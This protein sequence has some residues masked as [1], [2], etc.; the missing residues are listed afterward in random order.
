MVKIAE[1]YPLVGGKA[2][3]VMESMQTGW[4]PRKVKI[5]DFEGVV[6]PAEVPVL[7]KPAQ[8]AYGKGQDQ[9]FE[10]GPWQA[11]VPSRGKQAPT[12]GELLKQG[13]AKRFS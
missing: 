2:A 13:R 7:G 4:P 9:Q 1:L 11:M 5:G 8:A 3:Q 6:A 10:V 12:Y